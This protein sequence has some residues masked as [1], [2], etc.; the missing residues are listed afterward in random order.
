MVESRIVE[1]WRD[2]SLIAL[3]FACWTPTDCDCPTECDC[4]TAVAFAPVALIDVDGRHVF[5]LVHVKDNVVLSDVMRNGNFFYIR[6]DITDYEQLKGLATTIFATPDVQYPYTDV[7]KE[8]LMGLINAVFRQHHL[9]AFDSG[10][11]AIELYQAS[12]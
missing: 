10:K 6:N 1:F 5:D 11:P 3:C 7:G 12:S 8:Q 9:H 2:Q 4:P